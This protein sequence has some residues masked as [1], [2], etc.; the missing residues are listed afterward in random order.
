MEQFEK[1]FV[2]LNQKMEVISGDILAVRSELG[3]IREF[4]EQH[5]SDLRLCKLAIE[6]LDDKI[7]GVDGKVERALT[8]LHH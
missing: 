5:Q 1:W 4:I 6:R 7:D 2:T 3:D 8:L